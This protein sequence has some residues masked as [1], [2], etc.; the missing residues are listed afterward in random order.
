MKAT[1][2][3]YSN[4]CEGLKEYAMILIQ[5]NRIIDAVPVLNECWD[6]GISGNGAFEFMSALMENCKEHQYL[7]VAWLFE[8]CMPNMHRVAMESVLRK[9]A[10]MHARFFDSEGLNYCNLVLKNRWKRQDKIRK[11][12][13]LII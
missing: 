10:K 9:R 11:D 2:K 4:R 7:Q 1:V 3:K 5:E 8:E 12:F 6:K 13:C